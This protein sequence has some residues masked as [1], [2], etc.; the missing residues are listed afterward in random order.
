MLA[1]QAMGRKLT[2]AEVSRYWTGRALD[3]IVSRPGDWLKLVTKKFMLLCNATEI[4]DTEDQYTYSEWSIPLRLTGYVCHFGT[5]APLALF[6]VWATRNK[7][8]KLWLLY[9][10]PAIYMASTLMFYV[11]GRYRYP[12][13]PFLVLFASAGIVQWRALLSAKWLQRI[14]C[15]MAIIA[16]AVFCNWPM[17]Y[18]DITRAMT[19]NNTANALVSQGEINEAISCYRQAVRI[20]PDYAAAH[21]N[22]GIA[23]ESQGKLSEAISH[24]YQALQIKPDY[25]KVHS[26]LGRVLSM[27][28]KLNGAVNH[29]RQALDIKPD[30]VETRYK[31]GN[32]LKSQGKLDE[33]ISHY[34]QALQ[35]TPDNA[36]MHYNLGNILKSQGELDE[37]ISHYREALQLDPHS[38][39]MHNN[40]ANTLRSQGKLDEAVRHYRQAIRNNPDYAPA[41]NNLAYTL[42]SKGLLNEAFEHFQEAMRLKPDWPSSLNGLALILATH[43]DPQIR[44]ADQA[45]ALAERAAELTQHQNVTILNTLAVS[46]AAAGKFD[47]AI[48]TAQAALALARA[49]KDDELADHI[50]KQLETYRQANP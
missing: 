6:G 10:M 32:I 12:I 41:H 9:L 21:N 22:L 18:K 20:W 25:F 17:T 26:G 19:Y 23:L 27:Q 35:I 48:A 34:R 45:I 50:R 14:A 44:N 3:Y 28:D 39:D 29:Y 33:A 47:R 31:L 40:L 4:A 37:A 43:P 46:Y 30:D 5:L 1:E 16:T 42:I 13:V 38:A 15:V 2:A 24:Y 7:R 8:K 36:E 49:Q 11:F